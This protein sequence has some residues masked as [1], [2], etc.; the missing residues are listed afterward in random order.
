MP[1]PSRTIYLLRIF[2]LKNN[3]ML[4]GVENAVSQ[5]EQ[6]GT[7]FYNKLP[8]TV[9]FIQQYQSLCVCVCAINTE[10]TIYIHI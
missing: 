5:C 6:S 4:W 3:F 1:N 10:Y 7:H 2:C 9:R 8:S